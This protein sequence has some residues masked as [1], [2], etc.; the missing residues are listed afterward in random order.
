MTVEQIRLA[1]MRHISQHDRPVVPMVDY[2][3]LMGSTKARENR[4]QM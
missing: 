4:V 3:Q 1:T 2:L